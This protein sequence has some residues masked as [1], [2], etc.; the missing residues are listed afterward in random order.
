MLLVFYPFHLKHG[1]SDKHSHLFAE[2]IGKSGDIQCVHKLLTRQNT[3]DCEKAP[4]V[5]SHS[6]EGI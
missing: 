4:T 1:S 5:G 3:Q 6:P 2:A